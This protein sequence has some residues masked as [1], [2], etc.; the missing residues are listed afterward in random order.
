MIAPLGRVLRWVEI[1]SRY[2]DHSNSPINVLTF[3]CAGQSCLWVEPNSTLLELSLR[4]DIPHVAACGGK[5]VCSTCRVEVLEG[6]EHLASPTAAEQAIAKRRGWGPEIRL[7]CET[8]F[9]GGGPVRLRRMITPPEERKKQRRIEKQQ[10]LGRIQ[11]LAVLFADMRNFT[12]ITEENPAF[13][14]I[15]I[16]NRYFTTLERAI[17]AE[18]GRVNLCVGDEISA[19]FGLEEDPH[20]ACRQAVDAGLRMQHNLSVLSRTVE[21]EFG[22]QLSIGVGVHFGPVIVG[23]VGPSKDLKLGLVGDTVN[24]ASRLQA[25]TRHTGDHLLVSSSVLELLD[26]ERYTLGPLHALDLK[27]VKARV[28]AR[29]VLASAADL[30]QPA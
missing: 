17:T 30:R 28:E 16:L 5:G 11:P 12:P 9:T 7:A 22:V 23:M 2:L 4:D 26:P 19:V 1:E 3:E 18:G 10:G 25:A 8:R 24:V 21:Q 14:V 13:D 6:L 27:G 20:V 15:Y 29:A